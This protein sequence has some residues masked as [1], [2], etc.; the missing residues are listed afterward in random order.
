LLVI[1][2]LK[3]SPRFN[4]KVFIYGIYTYDG[5]DIIDVQWFKT[6]KERDKEDKNNGKRTQAT[7][8]TLSVR[9]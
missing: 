8:P 7:P 5:E 1:A 9:D 2:G 4:F 6:E 3:Y